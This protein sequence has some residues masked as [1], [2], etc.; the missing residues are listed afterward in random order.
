M[1]DNNDYTLAWQAYWAFG[2][3]ATL[4]WG[5]LIRVYRLSAVKLWAFLAVAFLLLL[6]CRHPEA[7]E[8][9]MPATIGAAL[10]VMTSG[11]ESAMAAVI[12]VGA[13]QLFAIVAAIVWALVAPRSASSAPAAEKA[14]ERVEPK[15]SA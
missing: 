12:I 5:L 13:G 14:G 4:L 6:P 7:V 1:I 11:I 2:V 8:L 15:V 9:W 3:V 10:S